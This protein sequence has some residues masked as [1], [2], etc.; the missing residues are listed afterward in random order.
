MKR[1]VFH[2][3]IPDDCVDARAAGEAGPTVGG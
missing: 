2:A 3:E 1:I